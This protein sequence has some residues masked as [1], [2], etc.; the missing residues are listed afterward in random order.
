MLK[1]CAVCGKIH[2]INKECRP[3]VRRK[4]SYYERYK[5]D[6]RSNFRGSWQ[7]KNKREEIKQRDHYLCQVC[8]VNKHRTLKVFNS[9]GLEVHH[10]EPLKDKPELKLENSNLITLCTYHHKMADK[11]IIKKEELKK[12]INTP[13]ELKKER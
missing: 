3:K 4:Q 1:T 12:I 5:E 9:E 7:W 8:R 6:D 10:I 11:G 13:L 2:D